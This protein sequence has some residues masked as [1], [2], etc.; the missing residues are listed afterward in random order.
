MVVLIIGKLEQVCAFTMDRMLRAC[1]YVDDGDNIQD[2][3][4]GLPIG[5]YYVVVTSLQ[6]I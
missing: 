4:N 6:R 5:T 2:G 3:M 1:G